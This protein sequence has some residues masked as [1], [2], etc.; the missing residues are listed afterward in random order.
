MSVQ[1]LPIIAVLGSGE[2]EHS[3]RTEPLG[4]WLAELGVHLLTGG[5]GGV[6][7]AVSRA[8]VSIRPRKGLALGVIPAA[9]MHDRRRPKAGYPNPFVEVPI[10]T[11]LPLS[12]RQG[13]DDLS[14]NH[15]IIL[16]CDLAIALPG[17]DG[18]A[19]EV[20]LAVKYGKNLIGFL[21]DRAEFPDFP[22]VAAVADNLAAIQKFVV[23][24][25]GKPPGVYF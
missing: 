22:S 9:G 14:R 10:F 3:D 21:K 7:N 8:F 16:T 13:Q 2:H 1:R 25:I 19:S 4:R 5:G 20:Q 15:I 18:T 6:M 11:H 24:R 12:G 23:D 17:G